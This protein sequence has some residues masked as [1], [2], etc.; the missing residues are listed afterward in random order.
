MQ[1][2]VMQGERTN[3]KH[4]TNERGYDRV[5]RRGKTGKNDSEEGQEGLAKIPV[6]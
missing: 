2:L 4:T 6:K 5:S 1:L 3:R